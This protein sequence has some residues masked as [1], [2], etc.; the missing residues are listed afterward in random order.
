[1]A[2][3]IVTHTPKSLFINGVTFPHGKGQCDERERELEAGLG[4][5]GGL[6]GAAAEAEGDGAGDLFLSNAAL[7]PGRFAAGDGAQEDAGGRHPAE[8]I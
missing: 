6:P 7:A 2:N 8:R 5:G 4:G 1:M 3:I